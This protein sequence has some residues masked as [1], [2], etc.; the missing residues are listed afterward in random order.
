MT[1]IEEYLI[2]FGLKESDVHLL[3]LIPLIEMIWADGTNQEAEI[4]LLCRF[5]VEHLSRISRENPE[6]ALPTEESANN[7]IRRF[8]AERP[9]P[10]M[11][12]ELRQLCIKKLAHDVPEPLSSNSKGEILNYCMDVAAAC[13]EA[14]PYKFNERI[15]EQE[16]ILLRTLF[17][18]LAKNK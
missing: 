17:Q 16:K 10:A 1:N 12:K 7:F 13:V 9:D 5:T 4:N 11:L 3:E 2:K 8:C 14:Y 15:V 6:A 18:S